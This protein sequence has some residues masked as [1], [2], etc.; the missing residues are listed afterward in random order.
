MSVYQ[1]FSVRADNGCLSFSGLFNVKSSDLNKL[2]K[3]SDKAVLAAFTL[4][5]EIERVI[6]RY[7]YTDINKALIFDC[8]A[9]A[10]IESYADNIISK[11]A[12]E[13]KKD[14]L[15]LTNRFSCGYG[16]F[17]LSHQSD[18]IAAL[19]ARK[20]MGLHSDELNMLYP[21]KSMTAVMGVTSGEI[22]HKYYAD[23]ADCAAKNICKYRKAGKRCAT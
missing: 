18:I 6:K 2:L 5:G 7:S 23:C 22:N 11:L 4:G 17:S 8:C 15:N 12:L 21:K 3:Y 9:L 14:N 1:I 20:R 13:L 16:D 19:S 10:A